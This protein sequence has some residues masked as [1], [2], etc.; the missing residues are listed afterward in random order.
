[1]SGRRSPAALRALVMV[2]NLTMCI[3]QA[4]GPAHIADV[5]LDLAVIVLQPHVVPFLLVAAENADFG[6]IGL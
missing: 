2:R 1:M 4:F 5:E 6:D 3:Q